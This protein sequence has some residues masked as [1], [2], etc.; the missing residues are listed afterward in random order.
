[1]ELSRTNCWSFLLQRGVYRQARWIP[2]LS[3]IFRGLSGCRRKKLPR[4]PWLLGIDQATNKLAVYYCTRKT[5][6]IESNFAAH[7][8]F[9]VFTLSFAQRITLEDKWPSPETWLNGNRYVTWPPYR[10]HSVWTLLLIACNYF[11]G[12][13]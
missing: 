5:R 9:E 12:S 10:L 4:M 6:V 2:S 7:H 3:V 8:S 1:M 13:K 11:S